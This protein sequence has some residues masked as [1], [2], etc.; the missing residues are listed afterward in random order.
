[1]LIEIEM[2]VVIEM[3][4]HG[5]KLTKWKGNMLLDLEKEW[6]EAEGFS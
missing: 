2:I 5:C 4:L 1:M 3:F 6:G